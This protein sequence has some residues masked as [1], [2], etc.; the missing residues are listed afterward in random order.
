M[1]T[2]GIYWPLFFAQLIN[3]GLLLIW[4]VLAVIALRGLSRAGF[5]PGVTLGWAALIVVVPVLGAAAFLIVNQ[6]RRG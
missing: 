1:E 3:L 4:I 2:V 5:G 6:P